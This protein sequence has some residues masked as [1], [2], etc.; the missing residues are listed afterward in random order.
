MLGDLEARLRDSVSAIHVDRSGSTGLL[1]AK[2]NSRLDEFHQAK[3]VVEQA[4]AN[5]ASLAR[6]IQRSP[7]GRYDSWASAQELRACCPP[8][9]E[10]P[11]HRERV[12]FTEAAFQAGQGFDPAL[13]REREPGPIVTRTLSSDLESHASEDRAYLVWTKGPEAGCVYQIVPKLSEAALRALPSPKQLRRDLDDRL[14]AFAKCKDPETFTELQRYVENVYFGEKERGG[15]RE[16]RLFNLQGAG[17]AYDE[18]FRPIDEGFQAWM[19]AEAQRLEVPQLTRAPHLLVKNSALFAGCSLEELN[20]R[21]CAA[22]PLSLLHYTS[23]AAL[24]GILQLG[25][26]T[27]ANELQH[28]GVTKSSGEG[29][30]KER[31]ATPA[32]LSFFADANTSTPM[33][34]SF[35]PRPI[36]EFPVAFAW[37][38]AHALPTRKVPGCMGGEEVATFEPLQ[39][40]Q[41]VFVPPFAVDEVSKLLRTH[42]YL[43]PQVLPFGHQVPPLLENQGVAPSRHFG[44]SF[45]QGS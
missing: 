29:G 25:G 32:Y 4:R 23:S 3:T 31:S 2:L 13:L 40:A 45:Q 20:Q 19:T 44:S 12:S 6:C 35:G 43:T 34:D 21:H 10:Q 15:L 18:I 22:G 37:D 36:T 28:R 5:A 14:L 24:S 42:G 39:H 9:I 27:P 26:L 7:H 30:P 1:R 16:A 38:K 41:Y 17:A 8:C 33:A 11:P